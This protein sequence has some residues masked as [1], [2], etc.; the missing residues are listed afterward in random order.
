LE[1][2]SL[3]LIVSASYNTFL[4]LLPLRIKMDPNLRDNLVSLKMLAHLRQKLAKHLEKDVDLRLEELLKFLTLAAEIKMGFLPISPELDELWH[5]FIL[6]TQEYEALCRKLGTFIHHTAIDALPFAG[7][8]LVDSDLQF[9][10]S[11]VKRFG[12]FSPDVCVC[13]P[14]VA[15]I[16]DYFSLDLDGLNKF[17]LE[18]AEET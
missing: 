4:E 18:L 5:L 10:V 12:S 17:A 14:A 9:I 8:A 7:H 2:V 15:R 6:E 16:M 11:Y 3:G 13:W 1:A